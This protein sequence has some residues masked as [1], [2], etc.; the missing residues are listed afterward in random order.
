MYYFF[1]YMI[2]VV[3]VVSFTIGY[4]ILYRTK[5][6]DPKTADLQTGRR[7]LEGEEL[8]MLNEYYKRSALRRFYTYIQLW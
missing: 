1:Q 8:E 5:I 7:T 2:G 4:K 6:R 3:T